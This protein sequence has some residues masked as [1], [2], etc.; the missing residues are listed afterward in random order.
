MNRPIIAMFTSKQDEQYHLISQDYMGALWDHGAL[1]VPVLLRD[2]DEYVS[3][4]A[5]SFD[6]YMFCGGGDVD[7]ALYGE[8]KEER[9]ANICSIRDRCELEVFEKVYKAGKP[10]LGICRGLQIMNVALG[11]SLYQHIEGHR[12]ADEPRSIHEQAVLVE[13]DSFLMDIIEENK[14]FVNTYHHQ[15]IK[16]LSSELTTDAFAE[17]GV[18]EAVHAKDKRFCLGVQ[19]HPENFY[20][21]EK[22]A[23]KIFESFVKACIQPTAQN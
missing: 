13:K 18:I 1:G 23:S 22:S 4:I 21:L 20:R 7:P 10:I 5:E 14:I 11:G 16:K 8:I 12:Q 9:T 17:D 6:G 19:W 2:D 3:E 15:A